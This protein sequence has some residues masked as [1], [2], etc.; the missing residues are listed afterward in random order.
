MVLR[1]SR[2]AVGLP[3]DGDMELVAALVEG[4]R[5]VDEEAGEDGGP[6]AWHLDG[7]LAE[8]TYG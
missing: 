2:L 5:R 6:V 8:G 7:K 4:G 3:Q 1:L